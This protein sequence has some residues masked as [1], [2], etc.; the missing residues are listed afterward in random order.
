ME[1]WPLKGAPETKEFDFQAHAASRS[2]KWLY[3]KDWSLL[4]LSC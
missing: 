3:R 4:I 2:P 1:F